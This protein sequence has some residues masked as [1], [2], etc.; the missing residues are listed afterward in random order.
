MS[1]FRKY[2]RYSQ[3][4][5]SGRVL[6]IHKIHTFVYLILKKLAVLPNVSCSAHTICSKKS[7]FFLCR[8]INCFNFGL[9]LQSNFLLQFYVWELCVKSNKQITYFQEYLLLFHI[10]MKFKN[11]NLQ[12]L[13]YSK[14]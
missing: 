14:Y 2:H 7:I 5:Q 11:K 1:Y 6:K 4:I 10:I 8:N 9:I 3:Q 12:K 13:I